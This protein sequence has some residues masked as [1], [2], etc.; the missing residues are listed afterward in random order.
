L[1]QEVK[2]IPKILS[3]YD[4]YLQLMNLREDL[5]NY[6][7]TKN[8]ALI[9]TICEKM[10]QSEDIINGQRKIHSN[11]IN[12]V[13]LFIANQAFTKQNFE[14]THKES[15]ELFKQMA[16]K[17]NNETRWCLL[18]SIVNELRYPNNHTYYFSC[19]I[20]YLFVESNKEV[21]QEQISRILFER[22]QVNR[23]QPWGL[24]ITFRELI[25]NPK[26]GFM[27]KSFIV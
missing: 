9:N 23:P 16:L 6:V 20:L 18:N 3:N 25:Q 27:K 21:I 11:V 2:N 26:Y 15:M 8:G 22:L 24:M 10:M 7:R 13:V 19:I 4:N 1:L 17:L 14:I 12:A 5:E